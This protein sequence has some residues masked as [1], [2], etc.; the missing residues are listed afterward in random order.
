M[1][2]DFTTYVRK[3]FTVEAVEITE[4]NIGEIAKYIGELKE[5][6]TGKPYIFIDRRVIPNVFRVTPGFFMTRMG[7]HLR[8]YSHKVF[9][10]QFAPPTPEVMAWVDF[11]RNGGMENS[12]LTHNV[13]ET[14]ENV[15]DDP[16]GLTTPTP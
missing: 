16:T 15:S 4:E 1:D 5:T 12:R 8:C 10:E 3:P 7:D 14:K 9:L 2:F 13:F 6:D 11:M